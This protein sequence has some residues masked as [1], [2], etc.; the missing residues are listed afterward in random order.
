MKGNTE[1]SKCVVIKDE[2]KILLYNKDEFVLFEI[3]GHIGTNAIFIR[4]YEKAQTYTIQ[5][6]EDLHKQLGEL[7]VIMKEKNG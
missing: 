3:L 5:E 2:R 1:L 6:V 7:L 4:G